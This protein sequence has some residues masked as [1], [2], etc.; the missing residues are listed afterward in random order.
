MR[1]FASDRQRQNGFS[2]APIV[3]FAAL[4]VFGL[5]LG[6]MI[7]S[8]SGQLP[9]ILTGAV[10]MFFLTVLRPHVALAFLIA[11]MLLSPEI[12]IASLPRRD[13]VIRM[14][15][16]L[17]VVMGLGW[18]ARS[19]IHKGIDLIP[20]TPI[21]GWIG[22]YAICFI[23]AT[24]Q[25]IIGGDVNPL[26]AIFY[27]LKYLEYYIIFFMV[28]GLA[29][30]K[31]QQRL[32]VTMFFLTLMAVNLYAVSQIGHVERVSAPFEGPTGEP[33]TLGG[34]QVLMMCVAL[35]I[36]CHA[37]SPRMAWAM[38]GV[39]LF[40]LWP[41]LHTLSRASYMALI[42]AYLALIFY[43]RSS[44][45]WTLVFALVLTVF[46]AFFILPE[47]VKERVMYTFNARPQQN[48]KPV[49]IFGLQL[50]PSSS[51][52]WIDWQRAFQYWLE[53]PFFGYGITSKSFLDS[54]YVNNLIE[55]GACGFIAF[56]IL[57]GSL[58][59]HVWRIYRS[60]KD[61]LARGLAL[62]FMA[63]NVGILF[64]ALTANTFVLIR[65]MEPY[66]FIAGMILAA[67]RL[68]AHAPVKQEAPASKAGS[69]RN[70]GMLLNPG[71]VRRS[72]GGEDAT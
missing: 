39:A 50:D 4:V 66:W 40:T 14:E 11:A 32:Y 8:A 47:S 36:F 71:K 43:N 64:H 70:I 45:K 48:I 61:D 57:I 59:Y 7:S 51:S 2:G 1:H 5:L 31:N 62:G 52:R 3:V 30:V 19:A 63:G 10:A 29:Q 49:V 42:P 60:I 37:R 56:A 67:P 54:Q 53:R 13:V 72:T 21:N 69:L 44:R 6:Q 20:R 55:T 16:L 34:Y 26:K 41:F 28:V 27:V 18:L 12:I 25:G 33:N 58:Q 9:I 17:V 23:V 46:L 35:G 65:V 22:L 24:S 68:H 15:D 38:A